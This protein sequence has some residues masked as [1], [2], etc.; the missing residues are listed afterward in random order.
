MNKIKRT[1]KKE[2]GL[3][4]RISREKFLQELKNPT[5]KLAQ[6]S[7][8]TKEILRKIRARST[9]NTRNTMYAGSLGSPNVR[10]KIMDA[11]KK[12]AGIE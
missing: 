11:I 9:Q 5:P 4:A 10:N 7:D 1:C 2:K 12:M 8:A 3:K 6:D